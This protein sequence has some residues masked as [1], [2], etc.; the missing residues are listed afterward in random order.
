MRKIKI[1]LLYWVTGY[2]WNAITEEDVITQQGNMSFMQN[3]TNVDIDVMNQYA[4]EADVLLNSKIWKELYKKLQLEANKKMYKESGS[5]D[6][7]MFG[8]AMLYNLEIQKLW[9]QNMSKVPLKTKLS[10]KANSKK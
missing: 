5:I 10:P 6:D 3:G 4:K 7:M 9:L 1:K 8:K 2:L